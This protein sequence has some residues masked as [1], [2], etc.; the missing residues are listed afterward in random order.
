MK[1]PTCVPTFKRVQGWREYPRKSGAK[2]RPRIF[3]S[4]ITWGRWWIWNLKSWVYITKITIVFVECLFLLLYFFVIRHQPPKELFKWKFCKNDMITFIFEDPLITIKSYLVILIGS[5][6]IL[7]PQKLLFW[8]PGT[9]KNTTSVLDGSSNS[10][11][12]ITFFEPNIQGGHR[13][14]RY[15]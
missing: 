5:L 7:T 10:F 4:K 12:R 1:R 3:F 6:R 11:K 14:D 2:E 8:G 15:K 9:K 13:A